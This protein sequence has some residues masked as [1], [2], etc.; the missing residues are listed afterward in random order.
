[1]IKI[2]HLGVIYY[3]G[4]RENFIAMSDLLSIMNNQMQFP[5][6]MS[7]SEL[8]G[9]SMRYRMNGK[10]V[11]EWMIHHISWTTTLLFYVI[12][13]D[14]NDTLEAQEENEKSTTVGSKQRKREGST[15]LQ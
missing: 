2:G 9:S 14:S 4:G 7:K 6:M 15:N 12:S 13:S 1:M 11:I 10:F 5:K 8:D 3:L